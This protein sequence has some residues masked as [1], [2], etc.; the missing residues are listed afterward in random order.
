MTKDISSRAAMPQRFQ[1]RSA[2][3]CWLV[4]TLRFVC[5]SLA[6]H[7]GI[8]LWSRLLFGLA[9]LLLAFLLAYPLIRAASAFLLLKS[10][11]R[12]EGGPALLSL[13]EYLEDL[14]VSLE[15]SIQEPEQHDR[16]AVER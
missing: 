4:T 2:R 5:A 10:Y 15:E 12:R 1:E 6:L 14:S 3:Y 16:S 13:S 8:V 11:W 7:A 9:F